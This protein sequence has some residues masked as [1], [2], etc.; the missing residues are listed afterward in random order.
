MAFS[1][2]YKKKMEHLLALHEGAKP[3]AWWLYKV[4]T[5][6]KE[7]C[8]ANGTKVQNINERARRNIEALWLPLTCKS[9]EVKNHQGEMN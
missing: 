3:I 7:K 4:E 1:K 2:G 9:E 5:G 6:P 8:S